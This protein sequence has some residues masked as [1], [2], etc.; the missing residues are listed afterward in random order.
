MSYIYLSYSSNDKA[1]AEAICNGLEEKGLKCWIPARDVQLGQSYGEAVINA[2]EKCNAVIVIFSSNSNSSQQV[3][4]E[5]GKAVEKDKIIVTLKIQDIPPSKHLEYYLST[6]FTLDA[7]KNTIN[8][9][10]DQLAEILKNIMPPSEYSESNTD[11]TIP[12]TSEPESAIPEPERAIPEQTVSELTASEQTEPQPT[13]SEP[14]VSEVAAPESTILEQTVSA[15]TIQEQNAPQ[16]ALPSNQI[17]NTPVTTSSYPASSHG[18]NKSATKVLKTIGI[19]FGVGIIIGLFMV[20]VALLGIINTPVENTDSE[21]TTGVNYTESSSTNITDIVDKNGIHFSYFKEDTSNSS[22]FTEE[23]IVEFAKTA[24]ME[25]D[26]LDSSA[27]FYNKYAYQG[28]EYTLFPIQEDVLFAMMGLEVRSFEDVAVMGKNEK[29]HG[30]EYLVKL[31][32]VC[33]ADYEI[34]TEEGVKHRQGEVTLYNNAIIIETKDG[35]LKYLAMEGISKEDL[36]K[37]NGAIEVAYQEFK[38]NDDIDTEDTLQSFVPSGTT[39]ENSLK[40]VK[41]I[42][43]QNDPKVV[44]VMVEVPEG[45]AQGSGFFIADGFI[46]TN[47]HVIEGGTK[48]AVR[49]SDATIIDVE[50]IV[51][52]DAQLDLAVLKLKEQIGIEPVTL[53]GIN[54]V[55]KGEVAVAIGSPLGLFNTVSTGIISNTWKDEGTYLIQISIPITHGNS[56]GALFN[57]KGKVIGVTTSGIGEADLN[58]AVSAEHLLTVQNQLKGIDFN[59]LDIYTFAELPNAVSVAEKAYQ[60]ASS[61]SKN[62]STASKETTNP[63]SNGSQGKYRFVRST[64]PIGENLTYTT[65]INKIKELTDGLFEPDIAIGDA[66]SILS[67]IIDYLG[68]TGYEKDYQ[69]SEN[70]KPYF[71]ETYVKEDVQYYI[72]FSRELNLYNDNLDNPYTTYEVK[73]V[74]LT[75]LALN[76]QGNLDGIVIDADIIKIVDD[77]QDSTEHRKYYFR[78]V[79]DDWAFK[80]VGEIQ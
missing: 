43:Q 40:S 31:D 71:H 26:R 57:E 11:S 41:E 35:E 72:D 7:T 16:P 15:Q 60:N 8:E 54:E 52:A 62:I 10:I 18:E 64:H 12:E 78:Y 17:P 4:R 74:K 39:E 33:Y 70:M 56:G 34:K 75:E 69:D 51:C 44:A 25:L 53:G 68:L 67:L 1:V 45:V 37:R 19:F 6:P 61:A 46:V 47:Y 28:P 29:P 50:G 30:I 65:D 13:V 77:K 73:N 66:E 76:Q 22:R 38:G 63:P 3:L 58:F 9:T 80:Y 24:V 23:D 59:E 21:G 48:G 36:D 32:F 20:G 42:V 55:E 49:L 27:E 14:A 79:E 5:V 2:I